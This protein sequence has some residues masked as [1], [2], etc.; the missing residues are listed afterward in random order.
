MFNKK[1]LIPKG[2]QGLN[3]EWADNWKF[4]MTPA[5]KSRVLQGKE[6]ESDKEYTERRK[7]EE[8][9]RTW[10]S[11]AADIAHGVGE[12]VLALHPY[13]AVPYFGAKV[14][15]DF[16]NGNVNWQTALNISVPLFHFTP[17]PSANTVI[18]S[19]LEDAAKAGSKTARNWRVAREMERN[20]KGP[21]NQ[22]ELSNQIIEPLVTNPKG[23]GKLIHYDNG[24]GVSLYRGK[25]ATVRNN[26]LYPGQT[27]REGQANYT[28]WNTDIPYMNVQKA[29]KGP[30]SPSRYIIVDDNGQFIHPFAINKPVGQSNGKGRG[31]IIKSERVT[32]KPV[33][34]S[35][36]QTFQKSP[37]GWWERI[38]YVGNHG[39]RG[40]AVGLQRM[41]SRL[42]TNGDDFWEQ[43][44]KDWYD[45]RV[46]S[47]PDEIKK[48]LKEDISQGLNDLFY[49][50]GFTPKHKVNQG[51]FNE[52]FGLE[53]IRRLR[54]FGVLPWKYISLYDGPSR[55]L[56]TVQ[57]RVTQ[58]AKTPSY[59]GY[60]QQEGAP[61]F[62]SP[63]WDVSV[64]DPTQRLKIP[65]ITFHERNMHGSESVL[66]AAADI[67]KSVNDKSPEVIFNYGQGATPMK[68]YIQFVNNLVYKKGSSDLLPEIEPLGDSFK[69]KYHQFTDG[70]LD[71]KEARATIGQVIRNLYMKSKNGKPYTSIEDI[72]PEFEKLVDNISDSELGELLYKANDYGKTYQQVGPKVNP[73]FYKE[74]RALLK[75]A[76]V[77]VPFIFNKNGTKETNSQNTKR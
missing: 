68:P 74:L 40:T 30:L 47:V 72:R 75:Y 52:A 36:A 49:E 71:W 63:F 25:G 45:E 21:I 43:N 57:G 3:T 19:A 77:T 29:G 73:N 23:S 60:F 26:Q 59:M 13:T 55:V 61:G 37:F 39:T 28:W 24:D 41:R 54:G 7:R 76:P 53:T 69:Y 2:Q 46:Q 15:Q 70:S 38:K 62:Y 67:P 64:V 48:D 22:H 50:Y 34:L 14:G 6:V 65:D 20:F 33:D 58:N 4:R 31:F 9:K 16:L 66:E 44:I 8:T 42:V 32:D 27:T 11:S 12:G 18:N 35:N 5:S 51:K 56:R 10:R 1:K 17:T